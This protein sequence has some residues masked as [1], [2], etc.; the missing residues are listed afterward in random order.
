MA[1]LAVLPSWRRGLRAAVAF[2]T[3]NFRVVG[4]EQDMAV[5][6]LPG[7]P[8]WRYRWLWSKGLNLMWSPC[9]LLCKAT[10]V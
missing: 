8:T 5:S 1:N 6:A 7:D 2:V 10:I 4:K 9:S 3:L